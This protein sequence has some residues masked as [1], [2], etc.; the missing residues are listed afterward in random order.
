[1]AG[2]YG[3]ASVAFLNMSLYGT[4]TMLSLENFGS[5]R[6][7]L[8]D[9]PVFVAHYAT[10]KKAA[11]TVNLRLGVLDADRATAIVSACD[12]VAAGKH[13]DEF[14]TALL[15]GGG[16][17]TTN[18]N[19]NEVI[20]TRAG[21]LAGV[22]VHPNDHV[23]ASQS[24]NDTMPTVMA[25]TLL[26]MVEEPLNDLAALAG[27]LRD[28]GDEYDDT[29]YLGRTCLQDAVTL[30]A[31]QTLRAQAQ[32]VERGAAQLRDA[33]GALTAVPLGA[34]VLGTAIGA[35]AGFGP[36]VVAELARLT[37]YELT[38]AADLFD[39]LAHLDPYAAVADAAARAA[40]T[41]SKIAADLRL[42]SSGP[43]GGL[44]EVTV[45]ALQAGS[46]IMPAK[47]NPVVPE[48]AMQLGFRIRG[49]AYTVGCA[50]AAGELELNVME[51]V[52]LDALLDI[53]ED[54]GQAAGTMATL[55]VNGLR[56]DGPRRADN[57]G[58][59]LDRRVEDAVAS[60]YDTA[61]GSADGAVPGP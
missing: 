1:M 3:P 13:A 57:L 56:W 15:L 41:V 8:G 42:R 36:A 29:P 58:H 4:Q 10:V 9:V 26:T 34:T 38:P 21:Q 44:A 22:P 40:T 11:A 24:T 39:A 6:R 33:V 32:A 17:T 27:A 35:P 25:L 43:H 49:A 37:G 30:H 48:Y 46:S 52:I 45:P 50:V 53:V 2:S 20:A 31:G 12:E 51:P 19:V 5:G 54:L 18:M 28:K 47:V 61:T 59:A 7:R 16:G 55:C 60:G 14:P 23:N